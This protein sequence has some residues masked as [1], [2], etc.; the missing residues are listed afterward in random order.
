SVN[1]SKVS[2]KVE[3]KDKPILEDN[4]VTR[5]LVKVDSFYFSS[6]VK[7][8]AIHFACNKGWFDSLLL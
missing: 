4:N 1:G 8:K 5:N 3:L 7:K 6:L 2:L